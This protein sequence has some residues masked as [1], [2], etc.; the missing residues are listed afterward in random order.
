[1]RPRECL[2]GERR[3]R[4]CFGR[5]H[6]SYPSRPRICAGIQWRADLYF[7]KGEYD[8]ATADYT[9]T[10]RLDPTREEA[11]EN[12]RK[13]YLA[14]GGPVSPV[15]SYSRGL[16]YYVKDAYDDAIAEFTD[17][18]CL[19]PSFA[20]A[21]DSRGRVFIWNALT[22]IV[23]TARFTM[24]AP[25]PIAPKPFV[26]TRILPMRFITAEQPMITCSAMNEQLPTTL[27]LFA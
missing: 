5:L 12:R 14:K 9:K 18:I 4:S 25:S 7:A 10:I 11:I 15:A 2:P 22:W 17:A 27:T 21:F 24:I 19:D 16:A 1:M 13:A 8:C 20:E 23:V 6:R 3:A 26:S